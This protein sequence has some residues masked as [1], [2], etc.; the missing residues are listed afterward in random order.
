[1]MATASSAGPGKGAIVAVGYDGSDASR[2]ALRWAAEYAMLSRSIL[3]VIHAC[4][5][6]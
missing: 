1:M 4:F 3:R 2:L 6:P 5:W